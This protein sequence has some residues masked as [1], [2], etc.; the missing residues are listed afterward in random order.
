MSLA[1]ETKNAP[2]LLI[3]ELERMSLRNIKVKFSPN[4][5]WSFALAVA[6]LLIGK[7]L[8]RRG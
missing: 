8:R 2:P 4:Y 1:K 3:K 7:T 6:G 5:N